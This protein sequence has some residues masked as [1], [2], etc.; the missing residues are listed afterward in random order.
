MRSLLLV[1]PL[2]LPLQRHGGSNSNG[3]PANEPTPMVP[4]TTAKDGYALQLHLITAARQTYRGATDTT[5]EGVLLDVSRAKFDYKTD[6]P[7]GL[8]QNTHMGEFYQG[9]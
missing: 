9:K 2:L 3:K 5:G 8:T 7:N 6:C 4:Y 1:L